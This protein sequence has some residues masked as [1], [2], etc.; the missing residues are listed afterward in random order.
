MK[1]IVFYCLVMNLMNAFF[2]P[3]LL[4]MEDIEAKVSPKEL[5]LH[6]SFDRSRCHSPENGKCQKK[7]TSNT[8]RHFL[9]V[10]YAHSNA[11]CNA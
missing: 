1:K 3:S 6:Y 2:G 5:I 4:F 10:V 7:V 8:L 9:G 11:L